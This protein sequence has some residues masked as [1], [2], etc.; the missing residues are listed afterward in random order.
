MAEKITLF[1]LDLDIDAV[2]KGT[3]QAKKE[4]VGLTQAQKELKKSGQ[5]SSKEFIQNEANLKNLKQEYN[6]NIKVIQA[7]NTQSKSQIQVVKNTDGS[8]KQLNRALGLNKKAYSSLNKEQ[9][10]STGGKE[11][12]ATINKQDKSY[13]DLSKSIGNNQV[14]VGNYSLATE[15]LT[16]N[17]NIMGVNVGGIL[18]QM[19]AKKVA[20]Q[21]TAKSTKAMTVATNGSSKSLKLFRL[22][23]AATGIGLIVIALGALVSA[24]LSTQKGMDAV[25]RAIAPIKGAFQG[26]ISVVQKIS[27]VVFGG[28]GDRFTLI[29][30]S[31]LQKIDLI[32]LGWNK[33]SGDV[34]EANEI[35]ARMKARTEESANAQERLNKSSSKLKEIFAGAGEEIKKAAQRQKEIVELGIQAE[36]Q[37]IALITSKAKL[38]DQVK[39]QEEIAKNTTLT[40]AERLKAIEEAEKLTKQLAKEEEN[41]LKLKILQKQKQNEQNDTSRE[42]AK[43]LADLQA[44]LISKETERRA[45]DLKFQGSRN[46]IINKRRADEAK[47]H[48]ERVAR[49]KKIVDESIKNSK[50]KLALFTEEFKEETAGLK[51]SLS[52]AETIKKKKLD[53][54]K[55]EFKAKKLTQTEFELENLRVKNEFLAKQTEIT[56]SFANKK[57]EEST[58]DLE[59]FKAT[60]VSKLD[61]SKTLTQSLINEEETRL[62]QIHSKKTTILNQQKA[63]GLISEK[64]YNSQKLQ[65]D[66][67]LG[68][69]KAE[70]QN[71]FKLQQVEQN[72]IDFENELEIKRIQGESEYE[73]QLLELNRKRDAEL[74]SAE[75]TG[76][77]KNLIVQKYA[78]K[79]REINQAKEIAD[80]QIASDVLGKASSLFKELLN[81]SESKYVEITFFV[82]S[83]F[84]GPSPPVVI[85][86]LSF[87][88]FNE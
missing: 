41:I 24:F 47:A 16:K 4:I 29:S 21:A 26:I 31:I 17:L 83:S 48:K 15:G 7:H 55:E 72:Q 43:E 19:K 6:A 88:L 84:V 56:T 57:I 87:V 22:A 14:E 25:N 49:A 33:L 61:N 76:A 8:I 59:L 40:D 58:K 39:E 30:N 11:L 51:E 1:E 36:Q 20:V 13:K 70:L 63:E 68:N 45:R 32:R 28:L 71:Q 86:M 80:L 44:Q 34:E 3:Q 27:T 2:V 77:D 54:L 64:E 75:K 18:A 66:V 65:L 12:L 35:Q 9:R 52:F 38:L 10:D 5:E 67:E 82:I 50:T 81:N 37:E 73:L 85:I 69:Q 42:E 46:S 62:T 23:L 78:D 74:A 53:I 79:E 60:N